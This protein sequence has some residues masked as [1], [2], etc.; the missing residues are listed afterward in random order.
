M[1][2]GVVGASHLAYGRSAERSADATVVSVHAGSSGVVKVESMV[3]VAPVVGDVDSVCFAAAAAF[4]VAAAVGHADLLSVE[5][6]AAVFADCAAKS[7]AEVAEDSARSS[8]EVLVGCDLFVQAEHIAFGG[9]KDRRIE[10]APSSF[11]E[12]ERTTW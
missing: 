3:V 11:A 6:V 8:N 2:L 9:R 12:Y 4:G 10:R 1:S 5:S 7:E